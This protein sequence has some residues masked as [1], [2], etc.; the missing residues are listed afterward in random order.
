[1]LVQLLL[2]SSVCYVGFRGFI[3]LRQRKA[4]LTAQHDDKKD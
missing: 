4:L 3:K 2:A 1:M